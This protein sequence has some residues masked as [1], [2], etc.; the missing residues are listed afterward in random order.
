MGYLAAQLFIAAL[1]AVE[2]VLGGMS[3]T[4]ALLGPAVG[5]LLFGMVAIATEGLAVPIGIHAA[6]NLGHSALGFKETPGMWQ[7]TVAP[8]EEERAYAVGIA[9]YLV[10]MGLA[11]FGSWRWF[12]RRTARPAQTPP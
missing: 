9:I 5:S 4:G 10:V 6:W 7:P 3:W 2:H 1:F 8:G 12:R 11:T